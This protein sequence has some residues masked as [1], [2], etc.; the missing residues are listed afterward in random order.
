MTYLAMNFAGFVNGVS[1]LHGEVS[2][3]LLRPFWPR[4]LESEVPVHSITNGVHLSTWIDPALRALL[5]AADRPVVAEDYKLA[6]GAL[7][8]RALWEVKRDGK[9]RMLAHLREALERAFVG[10]PRQS[11]AAQPHAGRP[12][13]A[14]RRAGI[15]DRLRAALRALQARQPA[16]PRPGAAAQAARAARASAARRLRGQGAPG[17]QARP[18]DPEAGRGADAARGAGRARVLRRGLRHRHGARAGARRRRLAQ[19]PDPP[20]RSE[21]HLGHE[22]RRQRRTQP[23]D[24]RRLVARGGRRQER[25]VDRRRARLSRTGPAG[26]TRQREPL[27]PARG[28]GPAALPRSTRERPAARLARARAAQPRERA[29]RLQHRP[30]ARGVPRRGPTRRSRRAGSR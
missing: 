1:R 3:K 17:R 21:R 2:R 15:V 6:A 24:P 9:R 28:G 19:Q 22:G 23:L 29:D 5:G 7:D 25:L 10:A 8:P 16:V 18:G 13:G 30:H 14:V 27:P 4:Y 20:A 26:R 11:L 12:G